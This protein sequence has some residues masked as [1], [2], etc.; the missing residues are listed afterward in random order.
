MT[1][2]SKSREPAPGEG[3][4]DRGGARVFAMR[5]RM[6]QKAIQ[7]A[8]LAAWLILL[9]PLTLSGRQVPITIVHTTDLHGHIL[10]TRDY[11]GREDVGGFLRCA[12]VIEQL[13]EEAPDLLLVD[14]GD[15][16]QG[17]LV[18]YLTRGRIMTDALAWMDYDAWVLGNHEFDWGMDELAALVD[19]AAIPVLGANIGVRPGATN[20]LPKV[21]PFVLRE[22]DGVRV[23]LVGLTTDAI[24]TW[25]RPH[26]L[27]DVVISDSVETLRTIVPRVRALEP[28]VMVLLLHQGYRPFGDSPAN[29]VNRIARQFPEFDLIVGGH[30]HQPI[31][32]V[33]VNGILY[34]Q[35]GYHGIWLGKARLVYDTVARRVV[36]RDA[37][38]IPIDDTIEFHEGLHEALREDLDRAA[39]AD[40]VEIGAVKQPVEPRSRVAGQSGVQT[41]ICRALADAAQAEVV[42]HGALSGE[43]LE[44]GAVKERDLWRIV[45]YENTI[46]VLQITASELREIL[47]ENSELLSGSQFMGVYG[48][49]YDLHAYEEVG[50][51]VRNLR[52]AD[53]T[54]IHP[55][56]R[57]RVA[58]NSYVLASGGGRFP[59]VRR[60]AD[61][62]LARLEMTGIDTRGA[63]RNYIRRHSPVAIEVEDAVRLIRSPE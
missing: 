30:S 32:R 33:Q 41:L 45:P 6:R 24:P 62:P 11:D 22:V 51:R 26:L 3:R 10:P 40:A 34:T 23:A 2:H 56:K 5:S 18:G 43:G 61:D 9:G 27:G 35:A 15:L 36:D 60:I 29:Q 1:K 13:R 21:K 16:Y 54:P 58:M 42:L 63:V 7:F 57:L 38:L 25:S 28:D 55:R 14:C 52:M 50:R 17:T 19:E 48:I 49:R 20:P 37:R 44:P 31:E 8:C 46:G 59:A 12:T 47:E 39:Q 53:G 4:R